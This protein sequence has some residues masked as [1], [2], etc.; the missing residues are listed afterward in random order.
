MQEHIIEGI[1]EGSGMELY[2][3]AILIAS[4]LAAFA[5]SNLAYYYVLFKCRKKDRT[6]PQEKKGRTWNIVC[7]VVVGACALI[8]LLCMD[9]VSTIF[10]IVFALFAI[11]G[12]TV[13]SYIRIIGNEMLLVMLPIGLLYR[14]IVGSVSALLGSLIALGIVILTFGLAMLATKKLKGVFG[15]GMGDVKLSMVI[16]LTVGW[17]DVLTFLG[18]MAIAII[19]Y[20][21]VGLRTKVLQKG[22]YFPMCGMIMAGFLIALYVPVLPTLLKLF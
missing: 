18:G 20:C 1:Q 3:L 4:L 8:S 13:D 5:V 11:F 22:F 12:A 7:I 14:I 19:V 21:V 10:C 9:D 17:P 6:P 2:K 15:V 16:A